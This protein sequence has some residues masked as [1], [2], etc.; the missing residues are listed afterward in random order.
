MAAPKV[1]ELYGE[2]LEDQFADELDTRTPLQYFAAQS[3]ATSESG[4]PS[5]YQ[6]SQAGELAEYKRLMLPFW[7]DGHVSTILAAFEIKQGG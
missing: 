3:S 4:A 2:K 1:A 6:Y 7:G 5:F